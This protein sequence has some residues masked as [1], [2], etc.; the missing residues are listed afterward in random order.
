MPEP[1]SGGK[2]FLLQASFSEITHPNVATVGKSFS[3]LHFVVFNRR[4]FPAD[5]AC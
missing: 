3:H 5:F 4:V 1:A 2:L